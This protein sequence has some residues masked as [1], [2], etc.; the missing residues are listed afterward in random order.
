VL[1]HDSVINRITGLV[2]DGG[3]EVHRVQLLTYLRLANCPVGL[4]LNFHGETM[5]EGISAVS[6]LSAALDRIP[7]TS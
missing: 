7:P 6:V 5:K 2:V 4:I 1:S 3:I